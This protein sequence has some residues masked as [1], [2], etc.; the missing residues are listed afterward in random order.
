MGK[1]LLGASFFLSPY[2]TCEGVNSPALVFDACA[3]LRFFD[4]SH[5]L[6]AGKVHCL[7]FR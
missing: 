1:L 4:L 7:A 3:S 2:L 6:M 5:S